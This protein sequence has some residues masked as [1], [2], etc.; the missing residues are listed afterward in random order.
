MNMS[1]IAEP[2][3]LLTQSNSE[4]SLDETIDRRT[5]ILAKQAR[6]AM[7]L[8]EVECE[9]LILLE[10]ENLAWL[11]SGATIRGVLDPDQMP[12]LFLTQEQRWMMCSNADTQRLFDEELDEFGFQLKEWPWHWG[13]EQLLLDLMHGRRMACDRPVGDCLFVGERLRQLRRLLTQYEQACLRALGQVVSHAVE[14]TCR[15]M[16]VHETEREIAG[17]LGHR[18]LHRGVF[19]VTLGVAAD[20]RSAVYRQF[21]FTPTPVNQYAAVVAVGRKYGLCAMASRMASFGEP[22]AALRGAHVAANKVSATYVAST[23]PDAVPREILSAGRRVYQVMGYEHDWTL[24]PQGH[25]SGRIPVELE[26]NP[27]TEELLQPGWAVTWRASTGPALSCDTYLVGDTGPQSVTPTEAWPV[28]LIR[29][30]GAEIFR[31]DILIR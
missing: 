13:R 9:G 3:F 24:C 28:M 26:L 12:A 14:A 8:R 4:L 20:G 7:L 10:P 6:V 23:W 30:Q 25:V 22:D 15:T 2:H 18:L 11:T 19:P 1:L 29:V 27:K 5:D 31:P 21:G 16:N 17:Q